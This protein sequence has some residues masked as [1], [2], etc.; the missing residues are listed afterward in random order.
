VSEAGTGA[1][2][3]ERR[4]RVLVITHNRPEILNSVNADHA[5]GLDAAVRELEADPDLAV[6]VVTGSGRCCSAGM[7]LKGFMRYQDPGS[8][9]VFVHAG[10]T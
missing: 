6:G 8:F 7:D 3:Y 2:V 9:V 10:P 4:D 1:A 5:N